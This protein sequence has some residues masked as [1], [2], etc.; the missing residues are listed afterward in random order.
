MIW[1]VP[2]ILRRIQRGRIYAW[3]MWWVVCRLRF[4][5]CHTSMTSEKYIEGDSQIQDGDVVLATDNR[6]LSTLCVPGTHTH[7]LLC[8]GQ[9]PHGVMMCAEMTHT[10]YGEVAFAQACFHASRVVILRCPDFDSVY[11]R[12]VVRACRVFKGTPYDTQFD[13]DDDEVYCSELPYHCDFERRLQVVPS[14]AWGTGQKVIKPDDLAA[15]NVEVI[16]DS[17]NYNQEQ[18]SDHDDEK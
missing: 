17:D 8:I 18:G 16:Y 2:S 9:S 15:A 7:A 13:L 6:A 3:L 5:L 12:S 1:P 10:G 4:S 14:R 11:V